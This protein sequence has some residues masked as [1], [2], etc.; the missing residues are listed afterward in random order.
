MKWHLDT[1]QPFRGQSHARVSR[2]GS[3]GVVRIDYYPT[4]RMVG[5]VLA[6]IDGV[7]GYPGDKGRILDPSPRYQE[8]AKR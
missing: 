4:C 2:D 3:H 6:L 8:I 7:V 5:P 1:P